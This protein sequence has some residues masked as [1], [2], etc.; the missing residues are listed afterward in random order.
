MSAFIVPC[1]TFSTCVR[2]RE[3]AAVGATEAAVQ[4]AKPQKFVEKWVP[5]IKQKLDLCEL[6]RF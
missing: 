5:V 3:R 1:M 2:A 4:F 6:V